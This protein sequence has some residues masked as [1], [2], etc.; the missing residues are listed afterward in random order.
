MHAVKIK[1]LSRHEITALE[2]ALHF[3]THRYAE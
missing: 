3:I 2:N 1:R